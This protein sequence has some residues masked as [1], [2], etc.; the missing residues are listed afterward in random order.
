MDFQYKKQKDTTVT[1]MTGKTQVFC[2]NCYLFLRKVQWIFIF[3]FFGLSSL[4]SKHN[5]KFD[6]IAN[7]HKCK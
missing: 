1:K 2:S 7:L 4:L 3:L 6:L 5:F